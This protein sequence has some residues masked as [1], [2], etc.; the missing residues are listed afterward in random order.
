MD[1]ESPEENFACY[2]DEGTTAETAA[3]QSLDVDLSP[4]A[5]HPGDEEWG[6]CGWG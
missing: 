3:S 1:T 2:W 5:G 4:L 6:P